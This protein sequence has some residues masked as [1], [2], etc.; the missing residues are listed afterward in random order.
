MKVP[1]KGSYLANIAQGASY[2]ATKL[3]EAVKSECTK[4]SK[5]FYLNDVP[6]IAFDVLDN[7][8]SEAN[9]TCP[10]LLVEVS[11]AL[12]KNLANEIA[13]KLIAR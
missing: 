6:W 2:E 13:N 3:E 12:G 11:K 8:I 5:E 9:I 10:G 4:I 7:K 1:S